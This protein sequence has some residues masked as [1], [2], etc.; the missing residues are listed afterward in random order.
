MYDLYGLYDYLNHD[1]L[2]AKLEAYGFSENSVNYIQKLLTQI[3]IV[4]TN[5]KCKYKEQM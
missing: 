1:L 5:N 4:D 2:I 3:T